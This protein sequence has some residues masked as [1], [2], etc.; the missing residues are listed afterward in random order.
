MINNL[1]I[2]VSLRKIDIQNIDLLEA[3]QSFFFYPKPKIK[4]SIVKVTT[5]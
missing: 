4:L 2:D 1:G 5:K 3:G